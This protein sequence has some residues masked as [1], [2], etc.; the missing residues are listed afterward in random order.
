M[1][2]SKAQLREILSTAGVDSDHMSDAV[3]KIID[4]H[5]ASIEALQEE[6]DKYKADS[7][8]LTK[9]EA[10][11]K[12]ANDKLKDLDKEDSYKVK[13]EALKEDFDTYKKDIETKKTTAAK[14]AA[15]RDLLKEV[16]I[17]E[18]RIDAVMKVSGSN[19]KDLKLTDD[20]KIE[21]ADDLKKSLKTEWEDFIVTK[22]QEGADTK[23]PPEGGKAAPKTK[24][25]IMKIEDATERQEALKEFLLSQEE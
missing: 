16:G 6:R 1:A 20:G 22:R 3:N 17:A 13:Y 21:G 11:L 4:G 19:L 15:Y 8:K 9:A 12:A 25:E 10:D 2:L 5:Q 14:E 23:T 18:K 24:A 7:E